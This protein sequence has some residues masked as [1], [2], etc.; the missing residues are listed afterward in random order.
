MSRYFLRFS[1]RELESAD[2]SFAPLLAPFRQA[3]GA[4]AVVVYRVGE[5]T[6]ELIAVAARSERAARIP[7]LGV[8]AGEEATAI[9][10][11]A[12]EPFQVSR[13][14]DDRFS[15]LPEFLQFGIASLAI[16][17]LHTAD[18]PLRTADSLLGFA[19]AGGLQPFAEQSIEEARHSVSLIAAVLERDALRAALKARVLVERAKGI[20]QHRRRLSEEEAYTA[21][22]NQ[23]R[24]TRRPMAELAR[25]IIAASSLRRTA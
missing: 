21:L 4:Q 19:T 18:S 14:S 1:T 10:R 9:L 22:R 11:R 25:E 3:L 15:N 23:S 2:R 6:G 12:T 13:E 5:E 24:R 8:T 20:I 7:Q 16:F 17:P